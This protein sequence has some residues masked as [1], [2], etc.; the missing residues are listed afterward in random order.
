MRTRADARDALRVLALVFLLLAGVAFLAQSGVNL[1][2]WIPQVT[3]EAGLL[4]VP[5]LYA[6]FAGLGA[7]A[8][9]GF[10]R[11]SWRQAGLVA[12]AS[13]GSLWLLKGI[14]DLQMDLF[15]KIGLEAKPEM[16][17]LNEQVN[18]AR[19]K[20]P[21]FALAML[22][23]APALCEETFFRGIV[24]RGMARSFSP[25]RSLLYTS[26]LFSVMHNKVVQVGLMIFLGFYFGLVVWLTGSI[27]AGILA[28][29]LNNFAVV[30]VTYLV[31]GGA[32]GLSAPV[33]MLVPSGVIFCLALTL[34]KME[35]GE[36]AQRKEFPGVEN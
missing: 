22:G 12:A 24:L 7:F 9:N 5:L 21:S 34:L 30:G 11:I 35:H 17:Q 31:P 1:P 25:W 18:R 29:A 33:W 19:E 23:L 3:F 8:A 13:F 36:K 28:H 26:L 10:R 2:V 20:G 4:A 32:E 15:L 16:Q 6:R 27:W 14:A